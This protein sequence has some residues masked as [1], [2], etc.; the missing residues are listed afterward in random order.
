[1]KSFVK[2]IMID[3]DPSPFAALCGQRFNEY[4]QRKEPGNEWTAHRYHEL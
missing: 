4:P 2:N 1:M 3:K